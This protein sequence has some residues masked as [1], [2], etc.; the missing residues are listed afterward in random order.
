MKALLKPSLPHLI[1]F[2]LFAVLGAIY[3]YP[4]FE[5]QALRQPD[6]MNHK[7]GAK[8]ILDYRAEKGEEAL[9]T[10]A[11]F[12]GM[13]ATQI[14][15]NYP[16]YDI[17]GPVETILSL[18]MPR[19]VSF[20]MLYLIGFYILMIALGFS[21]YESILGAVAF[22]FSSYFFVIIEAGHN[23]K[24]IAIAYMAPIVGGFLMAMRGKPILGGVI[25][26]L[27]LALQLKAN[28][29]QVTYYM[30][31]MIFFLFLAEL[32]RLFRENKLGTFVKPMVFL[33]VGGGLAIMA[34]L[35]NLYATSEY[36]PYSTRGGSALTEKPDGTA[37]EGG[38]L[39]AGY[40][41]D[42]SYGLG[43]TFTLLIP[44][45]KGGASGS[46]TQTY[47]D[48]NEM[49][50]ENLKR[51]LQGGQDFNAYWGDQS[52]TSGPVY[53]GA[54]VCFLFFMGMFFVRDSL[55]WA[56]LATTI[57]AILLSW[58]KNYMGLT[59]FFLN[60]IP[61]YNK[62]RAVTII[63]VLVE[64]ALPLMAVLFIRQIFRG[65]STAK[66]VE[67][68][69]VIDSI[70]DKAKSAAKG[71]SDFANG[72]WKFFNKA[73]PNKTMFLA[74][75]GAFVLFMLILIATPSSFFS[76]TSTQENQMLGSAIEQAELSGPEGTQQ[77]EYIRSIKKELVEVRVGMFREDAGRSLLFIVLAIGLLWVGIKG[78][79]KQPIV[80][81]GVALL[82]LVDLWM[83]DN[84]YLNNE[85]TEGKDT[86]MSWVPKEEMQYPHVANQADAY[87]YAL[88]TGSGEDIRRVDRQK[89]AELFGK[90]GLSTNY[91][92]LSLGNPFN[93]A[94]TSWF[95][96]SIGGYHG[97]KM[98][99]YQDLIEW[100]LSPN[101]QV[102]QT[103]VLSAGTPEGMHEGLESLGVLNMLNTKYIIFN[104]NG[105]GYLDP[106][107]PETF[108][109]YRDPAGIV[110][111]ARYGNAWA[112][113]SIQRAK[114]DNEEIKLLG[115]II[116][117][118]TAT[119]NEEFA[120]AKTGDGNATVELTQYDP[121][122]LKYKFSSSSDQ[123]VVFSEI[124]YPVGWKAYVD[125]SE[126]PIMRANYLLRALNV[127]AGEHE[128]VFRYE[129]SSYGWTSSVSMAGSLMVVLLTLGIIGFEIRKKL[130]QQ[131]QD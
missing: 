85:K 112:V 122:E 15:V 84:R 127:P 93:D 22:A 131:P 107:N 53:A 123:L 5:G 97:A 14:S 115:E 41:V 31:M 68:P 39:D 7:G 43:E 116:L 114:T 124:Y 59:D 87:I 52:F 126:V 98:S 67:E 36:T 94:R 106:A 102:F 45:A 101:I 44:N 125:G 99:R 129:L 13:P 27:F 21:V 128:I 130:K 35:G 30:F 37:R 63:L 9:W 24:A 46:L 57:L 74:L 54:I 90:L 121:R 96:K 1:A 48:V 83:V 89:Q 25:F 34:N 51:V 20:V 28:H 100:H 65:K 75:S 4:A 78:W 70:S 119:M 55:R 111:S 29:V 16:T 2:V 60:N 12:S 80:L 104:P 69:S 42:W 66:Q 91:R 77:A 73:V 117:V 8:E 92:V 17:L 33:A 118:N 11:M 108:M 6:I 105:E 76:F 88:E 120:D 61:G 103:K 50:Q 110:N 86:Y 23:T 58:G 62:F 72:T 113:S 79:L 71:L 82:I 26:M 81:S 40:V 19:P 95:H 38:G 10:N 109:K 32:Y 18:G 3:F 64:F 49:K 47:G 56:L